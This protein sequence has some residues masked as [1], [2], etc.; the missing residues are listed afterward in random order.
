MVFYIFFVILHINKVLHYSISLCF[1]IIRFKGQVDIKVCSG[2]NLVKFYFLFYEWIAEK[3]M[4][5]F[6]SI[7]LNNETKNGL[8]SL[9]DEIRL[10][11]SGGSFSAAENFHLTLAFL[12]ECN[13]KQASAAKNAMSETG[14]AQFDLIIDKTGR[15]RRERGDIWWAGIRETGAL[16]AFQKNLTER[17]VAAGFELDRRKY[18]PH[19]TLGREVITDVLPKKIQPFGETVSSA[20][21]MKSERI[22][23]KLTYTAIGALYGYSDNRG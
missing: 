17:L 5:L 10:N 18:S 3:L 22:N 12:G 20:G 8:A 19:I 4:R 1:F 13:E 2:Y 6:I 16:T 14:F 21:L 15:F 23:G 7:N 11:S 9:R